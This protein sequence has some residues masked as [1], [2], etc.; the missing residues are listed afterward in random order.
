MDKVGRITSEPYISE[1]NP[2]VIMINCDVDWLTIGTV[3]ND[4]RFVIVNKPT[5]VGNQY[6][7]RV[8]D[9]YP[10]S[11]QPNIGTFIK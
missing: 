11:K 6:T 8:F 9:R 10:H 4:E 5:K 1:N 7:Y 2:Y 3:S